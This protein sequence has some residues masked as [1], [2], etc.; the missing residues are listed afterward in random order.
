ME[1]EQIAA[2][3]KE[4]D[5]LHFNNVLNDEKIDTIVKNLKETGAL[6]LPQI[7]DTLAK[8]VGEVYLFYA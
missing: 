4:S 7:D 3:I 5:I 8:I 1:T 2:E 6:R